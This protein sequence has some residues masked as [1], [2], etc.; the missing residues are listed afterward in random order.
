MLNFV[1]LPNNIVILVLEK[2]SKNLL[3]M[4][5]NYRALADVPSLAFHPFAISTDGVEGSSGAYD[6][7]YHK[8]SST[9]YPCIHLITWAFFS[10]FNRIQ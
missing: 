9:V 4:G 1:Y 10:S 8:N 7:A 3:K 2:G 5:K 6:H